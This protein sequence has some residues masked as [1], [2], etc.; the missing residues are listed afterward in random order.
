MT[1]VGDI[2]IERSGCT[3]VGTGSLR[4]LANFAELTRDKSY[5]Q[6]TKR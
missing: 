4:A 5:Y 6:E 2:E 3:E 1:L